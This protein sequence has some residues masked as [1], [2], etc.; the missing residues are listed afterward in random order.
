MEWSRSKKAH[1]KRRGMS[2]R[3]QVDEMPLA[4][5]W[6]CDNVIS[7]RGMRGVGVRSLQQK[8]K[9]SNRATTTQALERICGSQPRKKSSTR[10]RY[11]KREGGSDG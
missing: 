3:P 10:R 9:R 2:C 7:S 1:I 6:S 4:Q 8:V 11:A 5:R